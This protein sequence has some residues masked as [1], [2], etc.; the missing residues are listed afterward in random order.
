MKKMH[1]DSVI[2]SYGDKQVLS[3]IFLTCEKGEIVG[4]LGRNGTGK[5]TLLEIIFGT[6]KADNKFI[7]INEKHIKGIFDNQNLIKYLPQKNFLPNHIKIKTIIK[8]FC[9]KKNRFII[10]NN[11]LIKQLLNK[12]SKQLSGGEKRILEIFLIVLSSAEYILLDEP[13][14]GVA[15]I[16]REEIKGLIIEQSKSKGFII[17]DHSYQNILDINTKTVIIH[18]GATREIKNNEELITYGYIRELK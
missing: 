12:K 14:N 7:Q 11:H 6:I 1:V 10:K 9:D 3:D 8:L 2:K 16:H 18:D 13:F 15:P 4:L 5:S 17:T